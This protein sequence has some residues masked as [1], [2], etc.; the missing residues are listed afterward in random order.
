MGSI[1]LFWKQSDNLFL[2]GDTDM[3]DFG[4]VPRNL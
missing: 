2:I 1:R 4:I 3:L